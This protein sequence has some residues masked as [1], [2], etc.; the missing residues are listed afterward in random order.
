[1]PRRL[2]FRP[3]AADEY[4]LVAVGGDLR[5][6]TLL[7]AYR[8]GLFPWYDESMPVCW[9]SPDPRA[10]LPLD[11]LHVSRRL[12][13]TIRSGRFAVTVNRD[14]AGVMHGCADRAEGTWITPDMLAA[15]LRLHLLG[16][17]HSIEAW[18][19][20]D[21]AGGVYGVA[22][23]GFFAAE[24]MFHWRTD[25]SKVALAALVDRLRARGFALLDIQLLTPH[26]ARMGAVEIP[27]PEYLQRLKDALELDVTFV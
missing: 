26:T 19:G 18:L 21:L 5:P 3:E 15:Y 27:R 24:S 22:L 2:R 23:G 8:C 12:A 7:D 16:H 17:A 20:G 10:I 14:F 4:G 11:G 6:A 25:A 9:W 1:M 13:R